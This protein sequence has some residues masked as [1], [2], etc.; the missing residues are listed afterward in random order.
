ALAQLTGPVARL[1]WQAMAACESHGDPTAVNEAGYYGL[2]QFSR[3]AWR[4][5]G[6]TGLP[7]RASVAE[8]TLRAQLL[9]RKVG[10]RWQSQWPTCGRHLFAP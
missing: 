6:G 9:Y 5:V 1:N 2:Y 8:Q 10:G 4:A 7:H 3:S